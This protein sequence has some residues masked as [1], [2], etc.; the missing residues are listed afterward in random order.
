MRKRWRPPHLIGPLFGYD[1]IASTRRGQHAGL[2]VFIAVLLLI[3]LYVVYASRVHGFDPFENPFKA[4]MAI[5]PRESQGFARSFVTWFMI[6]Q[7]GA[8][9]LITPVVVADAIAREKERR[10]LDFLFV[11]AL[12]DREIILGKLGSRLAYMFGVILTGLPI[13]ALTPLFG[14]IDPNILMCEYGVLLSTLTSLGALS[15]YCSVV[16]N[17]ALQ[18]T[19]R[20]YVVAVGYLMVCPCLIVPVMDSPAAIP[21]MLAYIVANLVFTGVLVLVSVHDL[22][23]RAELLPPLPVVNSPKKIPTLPAPPEPLS[24]VALAAIVDGDANDEELPFVLPAKAPDTAS[25]DS[26]HPWDAVEWRNADRP[27]VWE[28]PDLLRPP[29]PPVDEEQPLLWKEI[30]LHAYTSAAAGGRPVMVIVAV[31]AAA[32]AMLLWL[33][34]AGN[35][36]SAN[37][38]ALFSTGLVRF[39]TILFGS[40]L[41]LGAIAHSVN[42][43]SKEREKDTL[44]ALL[45][46]PMTR[47]AVLAAKWLGGM[48]SLRLVVSALGTVWL[49]G[50]VTGGLHP[51]AFGAVALTV[52][53]VIEF[54]ASLGLWLSAVSRTSMRANMAAVLCVLLVA[55]GPWVISQYIDLL[56]PYSGRSQMA[57]NSVMEAL[58]PAVTWIRGCVGWAEYAKV[59][60]GFFPTILLGA[61]GYAVTAWLLWRATLSR[62]RQYG[63]RRSP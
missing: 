58:M 23:P 6:V 30:Y 41:G 26:V 15:L 45:A 46:I 54:L 12:T 60:Q 40:I 18:A 7:F 25:S 28:P 22:R 51:V 59:R 11:T 24:R 3:T 32:L 62:F 48:M 63:G 27:A 17:T 14:G 43:I 34:M 4:G 37:D 50:L 57:A 10:A 42:S 16:S 8:I 9:I 29:L 31:L 19:V 44:D 47:D 35:P 2:R 38:V 61:L 1:L 36:G 53:A 49:F 13:L 39:G 52:A 21:G 55:V 33:V 56:S 5:D 20:S